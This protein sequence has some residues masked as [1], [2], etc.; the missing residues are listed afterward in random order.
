MATAG[1]LI[2]QSRR[3]LLAGTRERLN[4]LSAAVTDTTGTSL[5]LARA[6]QGIQDGAVVG[7]DT[8]LMYVTAS[9]STTTAT[10]TRGY[11]G[12]TAATHASGAE[13]VV[14]PKWS[15]ADIFDALNDELDSLSAEGLFQMLTVE[16]TY[17]SA[18]EGYDLTSVAQIEDVYALYARVPTSSKAWPRIKN[19]CWEGRR[20]QNTSDFASGFTIVLTGPSPAWPGQVIRVLYKAPFTRLTAT[21]Q[22]LL[23]DGGLPATANDLLKYGVALRLA[24]PR[25][26]ARNT[27]EAQGEPRRAAEVPAGAQVGVARNWDQI[28][29]RRLGEELERL[30]RRYPQYMDR[31]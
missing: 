26:G 9:P 4:A 20:N 15:R 23:T 10:V 2:E 5:S 21:T 18:V 29:Q 17:N 1:A 27:F 28:R 31:D 16:I 14:N 13:V 6:V 12:T 22:D 30:A 3:L 11:G 25:E 8:E 24:V 19:N 7:I